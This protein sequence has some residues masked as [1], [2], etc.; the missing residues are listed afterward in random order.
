MHNLFFPS[1]LKLLNTK[2]KITK[3]FSSTSGEP[4]LQIPYGTT[5]LIIFS[6]LTSVYFKKL[7]SSPLFLTK[8][9]PNNNINSS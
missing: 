1:E 4:F 7:P 9:S 8:K 2:I 5:I 6:D 3:H